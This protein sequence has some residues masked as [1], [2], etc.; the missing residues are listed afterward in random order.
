MSASGPS[1]QRIYAKNATQLFLP[2]STAKLF[3]ATAL[4]NAFSPNYRIETPYFAVG[5][6]PV[7]SQLRVQGAGDP[8]VLDP[9]LRQ[10]AQQLKAQGVKTIKTIV[11]DSQAFKGPA[12][13][14]SW[15]WQDLQSSDGVPITSLSFSQNS[16]P[17]KLSPREVGQPLEMEWLDGQ[18]VPA[19]QILNQSTTVSAAEPESIS[20]ERSLAGDSLAIRGQLRAGSEPDVSYVAIANPEAYFLH[21][22]KLVLQSEGIKVKRLQ[23]KDP[24]SVEPAPSDGADQE[25]KLGVISS[26]PLIEMLKEIS[27]S[28]NNFYTESLLRHFAWAQGTTPYTAVTTRQSLQLLEDQLQR[29]GIDP[30]SYQLKDASG[31]SRQNLVSPESLTTTLAAVLNWRD[32]EADIDSLKKFQTFWESLAIAGQSG[33]LKYRFR[34]TPVAGKLIAKT[35]TLSGTVALAGF[36]EEP[37]QPTIIFSLLANHSDQS[38]AT[39]RKTVDELV[40]KLHQAQLCSRNSAD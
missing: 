29:L 32:Q 33:T 38:I 31:L 1:P 14:A 36:L 19:L 16:L 18:P 37:G 8:S 9:Q 4:V 22:L 24:D 35:G 21:R 26:P 30:E 27:Q 34:E 10:V 5:Q 11:G 6:P 23:I 3:T 25:R 28:S 40:L 39:L 13:I 12:I 7:L 15:E 2:A 17:L 20:L